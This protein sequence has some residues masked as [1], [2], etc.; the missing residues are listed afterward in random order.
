MHA[1]LSKQTR[2]AILGKICRMEII[3][4]NHKYMNGNQFFKLKSSLKD[5]IFVMSEDF[6]RSLDN[7]PK[8]GK[9]N[10]NSLSLLDK[11]IKLSLS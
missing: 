5:S 2:Q 3:Y 1:T 8:P 9:E 11:L 7:R 4:V 10:I 6:K